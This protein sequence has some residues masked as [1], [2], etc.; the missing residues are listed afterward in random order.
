MLCYERERESSAE[1][2]YINER[3]KDQSKDIKEDRGKISWNGV[4]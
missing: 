2:Y 1:G 4:R 3:M